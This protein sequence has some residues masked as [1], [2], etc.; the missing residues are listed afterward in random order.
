MTFGFGAA[1]PA[2][3]AT[4]V[5]GRR[6]GQ[7]A[8]LLCAVTM[9]AI[10]SSDSPAMWFVL[11]AILG[12]GV[13]MSETSALSIVARTPEDTMLT[14]MTASSQAFAIGYLIAPPAATWITGTAG[15][16]ASGLAVAAAAVVTA[17]LAWAVPLA[18]G[19]ARP[20]R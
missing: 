18:G 7:L 14:A 1:L 5:R 11:A 10:A 19:G 3:S 12:I 6:A 20:P 15:M 9:V 17:A 2:A 13:G 8:L 4:G 16:T